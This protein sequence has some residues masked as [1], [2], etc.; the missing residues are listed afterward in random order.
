M[1]PIDENKLLRGLVAADRWRQDVPRISGDASDALEALAELAGP[2][3]T[4]HN[5]PQVAEWLAE[6]AEVD[7]ATTTTTPPRPQDE[8][9]ASLGVISED[10]N[11]THELIPRLYSALE[12]LDE[13]SAL[14]WRVIYPYTAAWDSA[15][16][17]PDMLPPGDEPIEALQD[18]FARLN[19][20]APVFA[21]F[22]VSR[23]HGRGADYGFFPDLGALD[24]AVTDGDVVKFEAGSPGQ[25]GYIA[26][27]TDHGNVTLYAVTRRELWSCV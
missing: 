17:A 16:A 12:D 10:T 4:N 19:Y 7:R 18:L 24:E 6:R 22:G 5:A 15:G 3:L 23:E 20:R 9:A 26:E 25:P 1:R 14:E 11:E 21:Y 8:P 13:E 27:V 2:G